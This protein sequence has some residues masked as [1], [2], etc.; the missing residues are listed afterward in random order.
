MDERDAPIDLDRRLEE[1]MVDGDLAI[2]A[3]PDR[4]AW[5]SLTGASRALGLSIDTVRRRAKGGIYRVRMERGHSGPVW[6]VWVD[7]AEPAPEPRAMLDQATVA[8][9]LALLERMTEQAALLARRVG[10]LEAQIE[11]CEQR[12]K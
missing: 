11:A 9:L 10:T 4:G 2:E 1:R 8:G 5:L 7:G 3:E 12:R 6:Q